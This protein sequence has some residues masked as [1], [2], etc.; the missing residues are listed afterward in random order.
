MFNLR[1]VPL[2]D[3]TGKT[4]LI[5]GAGQGIGAA[6]V[7]LLVERGARVY[8]GIFEPQEKT[9]LHL[10]QGA[11]ILQLDVTRQSDVD[12]AITTIAA[13]SGKLD[14]LVN[15]A[16]IIT[17]IGH[18]KSLKSERLL[19]AYEVN[20]IG[21]HRMT[22]AALAL[23][24]AGRGAIV[25]AGTGAATTPM[26]GWTAYCCSKAGARMLTR[27]FALELE[28]T[29]IRSYFLGIPPTDT[30]M[31]E[32]IRTSGLNPI[33]Q[34]P[35][36]NLVEPDIPASGLAWLCSDAARDLN[37]TCLDLREDPFRAMMGK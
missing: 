33:S 17:P 11:H 13:Q 28:Q 22:I 5:T 7:A 34:I 32:S 35:Q 12:M 29:G 10:L 18:T 1:A 23:L 26:E 36:E 37:E 14:A 15:N 27:I 20:V 21:L 25:N 9:Q 8:A 19:E 3:M 31:Q 24:E 6:L 30:Q 2:P 16:G 4:I